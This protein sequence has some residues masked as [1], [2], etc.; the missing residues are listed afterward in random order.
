M[1][2]LI[3]ITGYKMIHINIPIK[4]QKHYEYLK[5]VVTDPQFI[6]GIMM[7]WVLLAWLYI[8]YLYICYMKEIIKLY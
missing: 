2:H 1:N 8:T 6:I 5:I 3:Y 4:Y 7:I